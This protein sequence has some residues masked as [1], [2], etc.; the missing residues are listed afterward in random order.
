MSRYR[1]TSCTV[2]RSGMGN[3]LHRIGAERARS[4]ET[5]L[6]RCRAGRS[7]RL[8][9]TMQRCPRP[10]ASHTNQPT[11]CQVR[12]LHRHQ[13]QL[14]V[15]RRGGHCVLVHHPCHATYPRRRR[16]NKKVRRVLR[17]RRRH[18][19]HRRPTTLSLLRRA[20][21]RLLR[22]SVVPN[23]ALSSHLRESS[24]RWQNST[25]AVQSM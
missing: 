5:R 17:P 7:H 4:A 9:T 19:R 13:R 11:Q 3:G 23:Q 18:H 10:T 1:T 22:F 21:Q 6:V 15:W 12:L 20:F 14:S 16:R 25:L 8:D 2:P 24:R